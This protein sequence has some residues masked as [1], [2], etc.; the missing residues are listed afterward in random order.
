MAI[1]INSDNLRAGFYDGSFHSR[2]GTIL[3]NKW[4][5]AVWIWD[6]STSQLYIDGVNQ[7][8]T[9]NPATG[10]TAGAKSTFCD[11]FGWPARSPW[12]PNRSV[13]GG[14]G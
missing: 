6:G 13:A 14:A 9:N 7:T 5:H 10:A 12:P 8:G 2:S 3:A 1:Q 11:V 4:Y